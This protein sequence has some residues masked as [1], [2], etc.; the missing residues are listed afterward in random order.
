MCRKIPWASRGIL[1]AKT[2]GSLTRFHTSASAPS[3]HTYRALFL[4]R[5]LFM[6][7]DMATPVKSAVETPAAPHEKPLLFLT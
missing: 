3:I 4:G 7:S 2:L 5:A 1:L 6:T